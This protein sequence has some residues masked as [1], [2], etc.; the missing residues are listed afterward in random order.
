MIVYTCP[1]CG[2]LLESPSS[3]AGQH[4][5]CPLCR[6]KNVVPSSGIRSQRFWWACGGVGGLVLVACAAVLAWPRA[7]YAPDNGSIARPNS[8]S[9]TAPVPVNEPGGRA[10]SMQP[11]SE[12]GGGDQHPLAVANKEIV[13]DGE[14]E[15]EAKVDFPDR[16]CHVYFS[17]VKG[18][19]AA[20]FFSQDIVPVIFVG[21]AEAPLPGRELR[22]KDGELWVKDSRK[23]PGPPGQ[24]LF[25]LAVTGR[26][27]SPRNASGKLTI[28]GVGGS[29]AATWT[30]K[31]KEK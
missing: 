19:V 26:F 7:E 22:L 3:L 12:V 29:V 18:K 27:E 20:Y 4:D 11:A 23:P 2:A 25:T 13:Y 14:W 9:G 30:A 16:N 21:V 10:N 28:G 17:V 31:K 15:G 5:E 24:P 8:P 6:A 1:K